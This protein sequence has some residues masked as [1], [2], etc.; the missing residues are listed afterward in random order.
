MPR[1]DLKD[2][3]GILDK[4]YVTIGGTTYRHAD[5]SKP[6]P[7]GKYNAARTECDGFRF[8]SKLEAAYYQ[9]LKLLQSAGVVR[10]FLRQVPFHLIGNVRY[11]VDFQVFYTSGEIEFVDA[12]GVETKEFIRAKK[13]VEASYPVTIKVVKKG[14]F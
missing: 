14:Q 13:Q 7:A 6:R 11:T 4:G 12:K 1:F 5:H 2:L 9:H 10:Y 8:D 3:Q